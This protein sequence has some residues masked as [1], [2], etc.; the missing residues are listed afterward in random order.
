MSKN[1]MLSTSNFKKLLPL[2]MWGWKVSGK[3]NGKNFNGH[4][5]TLDMTIAF[6]IATKLL[7][8]TSI[9]TDF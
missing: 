6:F 9:G 4:A 8:K 3:G 5:L 2:H 7:G 1:G